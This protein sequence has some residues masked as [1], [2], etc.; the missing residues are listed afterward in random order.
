MTKMLAFKLNNYLD[1][2]KPFL[3][4]ISMWPDRIEGVGGDYIIIGSDIFMD[5]QLVKKLREI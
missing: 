3:M 1:Y 5:N 2:L 4:L